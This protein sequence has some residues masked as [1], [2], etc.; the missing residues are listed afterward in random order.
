MPRICITED[1]ANTVHALGLCSKH[2]RATRSAQNGRFCDR[3]A[4]DKLVFADGLCR[5]HYDKRRRWEILKAERDSRLC[6][7]DQ[8]GRPAWSKNYC[9]MHY[10]RWK[11][12]GDPGPVGRRRGLAGSGHV[13]KAGY[14]S[15]PAEKGRKGR[16]VLEHRAIAERLLGRP[17]EPWENVHHKNGVRSDNRPENLEL[18]VKPQPAG[19]RPEDLVAWVVEHY[20]DLVRQQLSALD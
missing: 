9:T 6:G 14:R 12:T 8:C 5:S 16:R 19:Q 18:W 2:Y 3:A 4:C 20:P 7:V 10:N 1:C 11:A 17:L 13:S 15:L